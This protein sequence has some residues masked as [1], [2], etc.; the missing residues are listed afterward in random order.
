METAQE[1]FSEITNESINEKNGKVVARTRHTSKKREYDRL[2]CKSI[3]LSRL[4]NQ[5]LKFGNIGRPA[6]QWLIQQL[7]HLQ[8]Q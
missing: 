1:Y 5:V 2:L 4:L 3:L 8:R 7:L 6:T